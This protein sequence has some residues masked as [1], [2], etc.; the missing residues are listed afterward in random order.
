VTG[1]LYSDTAYPGGGQ[2]PA[3]SRKGRRP[4]R[5]P[6]I[7][8]CVLAALLG[9]W[10]SARPAGAQV[11]TG[12]F[13]LQPVQL[14]SSGPR[15][16]FDFTL[17]PGGSAKDSVV[18]SNFTANASS[19]EIYAADAYN[20]SN[21][22]F[23]LR[24]ATQPKRDVGAWIRLPVSD[25]SVPARTSATIPFSISVPPNARPG[26]HAGGIVA[27]LLT[28]VRVGSG[29]RIE[30]RE[31]VGTRVYVRVNGPLHPGLRLER[32]SVRPSRSFW[33]LWK[34]G[35]SARVSFEVVNTGNVK[36]TG[37]AR[38]WATTPL[39]GKVK[40]FAPVPI[41]ALLP[42]SSTQISLPDWPLP[43]V[44][45]TVTVSADVSAGGMQAR[46]AASFLDVPWA[47]GGVVVAVVVAGAG[48]AGWRWRRRR[49]ARSRRSG[50]ETAAAA[51][52]EAT[53]GASPQV[54]GEA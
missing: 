37:A 21:G 11:A 4:I 24:L 53:E 26:D 54:S 2:G 43:F 29:S 27:L 23:A 12:G 17:S 49:K 19:F 35:G 36:L 14:G 25:Y 15:S 6:I 30:I 47:L 41:S 1:P 16:H 46:T 18:L 8:A 44:G 34:G 38:L 10:V 20:L 9:P 52:P 50:Q 39:G 51:A 48:W 42:A 5:R 22:G 7:T 33:S 3:S 13:S 31:A 40:E 28:P 45:P 32:L